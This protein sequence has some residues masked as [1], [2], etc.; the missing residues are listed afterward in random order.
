MNRI[1]SKPDLTTYSDVQ[2][3]NMEFLTNLSNNRSFNT[4]NMNAENCV[5]KQMITSVSSILLVCLISTTINVRNSI[6]YGIAEEIAIRRNG[7]ITTIRGR[8][9]KIEGMATVWFGA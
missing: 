6:A 7:K 9:S 8:S 2:L 5:I 3:R 4:S 1:R